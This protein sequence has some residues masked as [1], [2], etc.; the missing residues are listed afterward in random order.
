MNLLKVKAMGKCRVN[1]N[2]MLCVVLLHLK[3]FGCNGLKARLHYQSFLVQ[4]NLVKVF[5]A[6]FDSVNG[7][8][9][10]WSKSIKE[11]GRT[12]ME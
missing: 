4:E 2:A 6:N 10:L 12:L 8:R 5:D 11:L 3:E 9:K 1:G 7:Q